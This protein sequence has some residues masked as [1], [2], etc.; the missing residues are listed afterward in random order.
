MAQSL[1]WKPLSMS[2]NPPPDTGTPELIAASAADAGV[3]EAVIR[4]VFPLR[5][6]R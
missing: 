5:Q 2:H 4:N 1:G 6:P 3:G